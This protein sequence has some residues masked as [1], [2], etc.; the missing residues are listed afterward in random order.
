MVRSLQFAAPT[1]LE[2]FAS[3]VSAD[4]DFALLEAA[5]SVAQDDV[6]GLD[7]QDV[8][9]QIDTLALRLRRR[10]PADA[11]AMQRLRLLNHYF[12]QELGFAGNVNDYHDRGNSALPIVLQ[13]RRG[14]PITLALLY[15]ELATQIGLRAHGVGFPGHFLVKLHMPRGEVVIDP[16]NG[17]SLAREE[18]D[19]RLAPFRRPGVFDEAEDVPLG[20]FLQAA[21]PREV[22]ARLLRNLKEIHRSARDLP[23]LVAVLKRLVILLPDDADEQREHA[24]ALR[25]LGRRTEAAEALAAYLEKC[26]EASD[27]QALRHQL[28]AWRREL[29]DR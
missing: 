23:R 28:Q 14:I 27:A 29:R 6:P 9:A 21:S 22:I 13:T 20:L 3:L 2:Y 24:F 5:I 7:V 18:L 16:V 15:I 12:F 25:Q 1:P 4:A 8:L 17:R 10:I 19:E 11:A 26:P